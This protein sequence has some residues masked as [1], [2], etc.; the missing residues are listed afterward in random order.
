MASAT[1]PSMVKDAAIHKNTSF[2]ILDYL[3]RKGSRPAILRKK[4]LLCLEQMIKPL[5]A[6][7]RLQPAEAVENMDQ[8]TTFVALDDRF[9]GGWIAGAGESGVSPSKMLNIAD[10]L[11]PQAQSSNSENLVQDWASTSS[12]TWLYEL[13]NEGDHEMF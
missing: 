8:A 3:I 2:C 1:V 9:S 13:Q 4:E 6:N 11:E 10:Q 5:F 7:A 12:W